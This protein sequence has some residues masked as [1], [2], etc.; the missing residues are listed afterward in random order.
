MHVVRIHRLGVPQEIRGAFIV[1]EQGR[2]I[3]A[4]LADRMKKDDGEVP[5]PRPVSVDQR[6]RE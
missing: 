3:N 6:V 1:L 4:P 2:F 5:R